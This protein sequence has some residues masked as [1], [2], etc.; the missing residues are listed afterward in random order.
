MSGDGL[1]LLLALPVMVGAAAVIGTGIVGYGAIRAIGM[2]GKAAY[3]YA[4]KKK[5]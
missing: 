3:N 5:Q 1:I 2:A 4:K